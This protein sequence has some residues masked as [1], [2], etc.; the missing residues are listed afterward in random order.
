[1]ERLGVSTIELA[2][3]GV[4]LSAEEWNNKEKHGSKARKETA[5]RV[6]FLF[7]IER[8]GVADQWWK[9]EMEGTNNQLTKPIFN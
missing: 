2:I 7:E 4:W 8:E 5:D 1:V 3:N 6:Q 9:V